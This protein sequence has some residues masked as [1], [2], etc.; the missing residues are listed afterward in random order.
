MKLIKAAESDLPELYRLYR[1][2]TAGMKDSGLNQW[3]WGIY[4]TEE[5]IRNDVERGELYLRR[6]GNGIAAAVALTE[7][8]DPE[9]REVPWTFGVRPGYIHRLAV[10]GAMQGTGLGGEI[11]AEAFSILRDAGC[12]CARID[13]HRENRRAVRLYE[14]NGFR[15]CGTVSWDDTPGE[16]YLAFDRML[17][18]DAP[19]WPVRMKPAF[20]DGEQ[21]PWGG[22]RLRERYGKETRNPVTGESLEVS[23]VPGLESTDSMGRKLPELIRE[24]GERLAGSAAEGP[25]P[26]L[27][28]LIA[29]RERLSVQVHPDNE[30]AGANE[31][32]KMGKDEA[33]LILEAP[34]DGEIVCGLKPGTD[35]RQLKEACENGK[36]VEALLRRVRVAPGDVCFIP[37]GCVHAVGAG[38][39]LYEIQE[40]SDVTYRF[41]DWD[42]KDEADRGRELHIEQGLAVADLSCR[43]QAARA[44]GKAGI[45]RLLDEGCFSLDMIRCAG[46]ED[47][48]E[49][50]RFGILTSLEGALR[51]CWDGGEMTLAKGETC[52]IPRSAPA[53]R[54]LGEGCAALA[55][56]N[57]PEPER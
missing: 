4:P 34:E 12:D 2:V 15:A 57:G 14:K 13:T 37:A 3:N 17:R 19:M 35:L 51:L 18:P 36:A 29:A 16:P 22:N 27:L 48:P 52:L 56:P 31:N 46:G 43:P 26:L 8:A 39:L 20:R 28:K 44:A 30:Y 9:Y 23:C 45:R 24:F 25:F 11:L 55:M 53:I 54:M 40:S 5:M 41:Y 38:M 32:G 7:T 33:W 42:R 21:T 1:R 6:A 49:I 50:R 47:L 10:D